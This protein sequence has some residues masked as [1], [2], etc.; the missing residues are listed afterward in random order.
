MVTNMIRLRPLLEADLPILHRWYQAPALW[1]HLVG[2]FQPREEA[3]AVA[4]MR[5]WLE[6]AP[7]ELRLAIEEGGAL[8][9]LVSLYPIEGDEAEFHIFLGDA[10]VRGRGAGR[11]ATSA[12]LARAFGELGLSQVRLRVLASNAAARRL[13]A[14]LGFEEQESD[15]SVVKAGAPVGV[16]PM[17][18]SAARFAAG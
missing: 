1:T 6:P 5:R 16:V 8:I 14:S 18:L 12:M 9:G 17:T 2:E 13:Y 3:G 10:A 15:E 7:S 11:A 4:Y